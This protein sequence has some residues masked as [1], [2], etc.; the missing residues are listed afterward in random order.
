MQPEGEVVRVRTLEEVVEPYLH[1][2]LRIQASL[3]RIE[4]HPAFRGLS[5]SALRVLKALVTR[6]SQSNGLIPI[7]ARLSRVS[8]EAQCSTK[9][10]QRA[11]RLLESVGWLSAASSGRSE[12]GIYCCRQYRFSASFCA[13]VDLPIPS[14]ADN[15]VR[16]RVTAQS[17]PR[18]RPQE[19]AMSDGPIYI[20][21][22]F[23]EDQRKSFLEKQRTNPAPIELP[24]ALTTMAEE[25]GILETGI[26]KLR[27][28]AYRAGYQLEHVYVVAKPRLIAIGA[29]AG[30][31]YRY[32]QAMIL[33]P[34][35]VDFAGKAA[36]SARMASNVRRG[37]RQMR[38]ANTR[39]RSRAG[40]K[41]KVFMGAAELQEASGTIKTF[42]GRQMDDIYDR[43]ER[44]EF[45]AD[46]I[47]PA[48]ADAIASGINC[49]P[50][51]RK[52][53]SAHLDMIRRLLKAR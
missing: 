20:D 1:Y 6:A 49:T 42:A 24:A 43:I 10:T 40:A 41:L 37:C 9:T 29:T 4:T 13:L 45:I 33:N 19:S 17:V 51:P 3:L 11:L 50:P 38:F 16:S 36:Q 53:A 48:G 7:R 34:R 44:G 15:Q 18:I 5:Q 2:P 12:H 32:L 22:T 47:A 30:R 21:L 28:M 46:A 35:Q 23:K 31:A 39:Y 8:E 25:T 26:C 27:G 14:E 52:G